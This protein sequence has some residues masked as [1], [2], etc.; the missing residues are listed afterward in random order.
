MLFFFVTTT[1]ISTQL[2]YYM[3]PTYAKTLDFLL[4]QV[5]NIVLSMNPC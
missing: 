4:F 3:Q 2:K 1:E 5:I